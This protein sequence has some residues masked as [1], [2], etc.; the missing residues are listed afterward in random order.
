[1]I[2]DI[3]KIIGCWWNQQFVHFFTTLGVPNQFFGGQNSIYPGQGGYGFLG[4][5]NSGFSDQ[6]GGGFSG[7]G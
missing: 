1:M 6:Q 5:Q 4:Q 7:Q 3:L 2:L